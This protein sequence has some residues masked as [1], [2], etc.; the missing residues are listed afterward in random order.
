[1]FKTLDLARA[2]ARAEE[3]NRLKSEFLATMS[4]ELRT[5]LNAILGFSEILKSH[6]PQASSD[7]TRREYADSIWTSG[8]HLLNIVDDVLDMSKVEAGELV[9]DLGSFDPVALVESCVRLLEQQAATQGVALVSNI[10]HAPPP[11]YGD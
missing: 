4:H 8:R 1:Y 10:A 7:A 5:P 2:A 9:L 3:S 6:L 11:A